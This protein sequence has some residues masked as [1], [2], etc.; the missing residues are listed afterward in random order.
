MSHI[1]TDNP[2]KIKFATQ[3]APDILASLRGM[4]QDEGRQIQAIL[5]EA[6]REYFSNRQQSRPRRHVLDALQISMAEHHALYEVL[7]K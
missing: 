6:L 5:D 4:A 1:M 2:P 7:S 3:I